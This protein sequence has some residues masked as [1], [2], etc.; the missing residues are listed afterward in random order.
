MTSGDP[1]QTAGRRAAAAAAG[2]L[3]MDLLQ[4]DWEPLSHRELEQ[5]LDQAVEEILEAELMSGVQG[6]S[7]CV[8]TQDETTMPH[9][10]SSPA[11]QTPGEPASENHQNSEIEENPAVQC[12]VS[13]LQKLKWSHSQNRVTGRAHLSLSHTV[14][15]SLT[16]LSSR[17]SYR[18]VSSTFRLEKGNVHRIF[19]SFCH[20][21]SAL[22]AQIIR[23][24]S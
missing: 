22:Q 23:W 11:G 13:L 7:E 16:L 19:F 10:V 18:S 24:P 20:R 14:S 4:S 17:L 5:R 3:V 6:R 1:A 12:I 8:F 2:R 9:T 15:L 21:V